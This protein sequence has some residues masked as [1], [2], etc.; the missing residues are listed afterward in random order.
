MAA[1]EKIVAVVQGGKLTSREFPNLDR[2]G[3]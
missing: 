1:A 2:G 3:A